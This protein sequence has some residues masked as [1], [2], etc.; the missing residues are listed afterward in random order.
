MTWLGANGGIQLLPLPLPPP[1]PGKL[2]QAP[3]GC[4]SAFANIGMVPDFYTE[5][6]LYLS[7][8]YCC[9]DGPPWTGPAVLLAIVPI[10]C[11]PPGC[12]RSHP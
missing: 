4:S 3:E 12:H 5:V 8:K 10:S 1:L 7:E 6:S 2:L 11:S 9:A